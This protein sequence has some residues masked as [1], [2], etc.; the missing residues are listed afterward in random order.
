MSDLLVEAP[1]I[2]EAERRHVLGVVLGDWLGLTWDL[3]PADGGEVVL[4]RPDGDRAVRLPDR[5]LPAADATWLSPSSVPHGAVAWEPVGLVSAPS[6]PAGTTLPALFGTPGP[7]ASVDGNGISLSADLLGSIFFLLSRYEELAQPFD[8]DDHGRFPHEAS[9]AHRG[10]FLDLPLADAYADLL[11][12]A[13]VRLWPRLPIRRPSFA[14]VPTHD[15][16]LPYARRIAGLRG[17]LRSSAGDVLK[18]RDPVLATRRLGSALGL[19]AERTDPYQTFGFLMDAAE[20]HG[21]RA[22]FLFLAGGAGGPLEGTYRLDEPG[23]VRLLREVHG[24]NHGIGLHASYAAADRPGTVGHEA[25]ALAAA[26]RSAGVVHAPGG[27]R[28]HFLRWTP[29]LWAQADAAGLAWDTT[30]GYG[31]ALG[32]RAGTSRP[33]RTYDL[34][35]RRSLALVERPLIAMDATI[36]VYLGAGPEAALASVVALAGQCRRFGGELVLLW[37]NSSVASRG[38][39]AWYRALLEAVA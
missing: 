18:R 37:H 34:V 36:S 21:L 9:V 4:R 33:Y 5:F 10:G 2:A 12:A 20:A 8:G 30:V 39:R 26:V 29:R 14:V 6:L 31:R 19:L 22:T 35:A 38:E 11:A 1:P 32:F 3:V 16:D 15:V 27:V 25:E 28:H 24:R 23:V 17:Q 7:I 13:L